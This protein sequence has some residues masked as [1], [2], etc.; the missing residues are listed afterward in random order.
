M[1]ENSP[2]IPYTEH[3]I[4]FLSDGLSCA[5]RLLLPK[6]TPPFASVILA[7]GFSGT[8]D[9]ILPSFAQAFVG[10]GLAALIFDYRHFGESEGEPRQIVDVQKQRQ[11]LRSAIAFARSSAE[12]DPAKVALWGTSLGGSHVI[13]IAGEDARI[14]AVVANMPALDVL[15]GA[16][17]SARMTRQNVSAVQFATT[18]ARLLK[19]AVEDWARGLFGKSPRYLKVYGE[20]GEAFFTDP[21]LAER[22]EAVEKGSPTWRNLVAARFFLQAP[23][24][25]KGAVGRIRAPLLFTLASHD[26]EVSADFVKEAAKESTLARVKEYPADHFDLYHGELFEQVA[27]DQVEFLVEHLRRTSGHDVERR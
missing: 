9:W 24:Y 2:R 20:P 23:R 19:A 1:R 6:A 14:A 22:F 13:A 4:R 11:D 18:T 7:N 27:A 3:R 10:A 12:L 5:G 8:M 26:V 15:R 16:D 17:F 25:R 21:A